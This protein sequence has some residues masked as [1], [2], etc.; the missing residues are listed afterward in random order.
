[1]TTALDA[2]HGGAKSG[3][4]GL[5]ISIAM[6]VLCLSNTLFGFVGS[7]PLLGG[8]LQLIGVLALVA[9]WM[10]RKKPESTASTS[11]PFAFATTSQPPSAYPKA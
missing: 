9:W 6:C 8:A 5:V 1:M 10:R 7:V 2:A 3:N 4:W 11:F